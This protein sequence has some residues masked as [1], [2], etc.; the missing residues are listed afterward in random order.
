[1]LLTWAI[2]QTVILDSGGV[3][4]TSRNHEI[5][6]PLLKAILIKLILVTPQVV[7]VTCKWKEQLLKRENLSPGVWQV[8]FTIVWHVLT[9]FW[10]IS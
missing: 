9:T 8:Y 10:V 5:E 3:M 6:F 7:Y 4:T 2:I 1:M